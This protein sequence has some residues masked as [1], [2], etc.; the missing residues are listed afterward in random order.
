MKVSTHYRPTV[1]VNKGDLSI[2]GKEKLIVAQQIKK[3]T[4]FNIA[5][6]KA[7]HCILSWAS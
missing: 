3:F 2:H 6:A 5:L 4:G 1:T 7:L